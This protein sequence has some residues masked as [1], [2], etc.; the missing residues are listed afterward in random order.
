LSVASE[1][2]VKDPVLDQFD[3]GEYEGTVWISE[4]YLSQYIAYGKGVTE[5]RARLHDVQIASGKH[6]PLKAE[7]PEIDPLDERPSPRMA[8]TN[9]PAGHS[10]ASLK[11][12][13]LKDKATLQ[14]HTEHEQSSNADDQP[15][16]HAP[17]PG[18]KTDNR[19]ASKFVDSGIF[20]AELWSRVEDRLS[21]KLDATVD[22][23]VLR[24]Q[25]ACLR[26]LDYEFD[27]KNQVW[28][29]KTT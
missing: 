3:E 21:V 5:L 4:I 11:S 24:A 20:P 8:D 14:P 29:P 28:N 7:P 10:L 9:K 18:A 2:K 25:T 12:N 23:T 27:A 26:Q 15:G 16:H 13:A 1:F 6:Q 22:R 19:P 17:E